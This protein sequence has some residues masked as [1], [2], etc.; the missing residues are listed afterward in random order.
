[1]QKN[2]LYTA[3]LSVFLSIAISSCDNLGGGSA[4]KFENQNLAGQS[5]GAQN[6]TTQS[7]NYT[8]NAMDLL[9][10]ATYPNGGVTRY[11][12]DGQGNEC[13]SRK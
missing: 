10:T 6:V 2:K 9:E 5:G 7:W 8:Y 13:W 11:D 4:S 3:L 1:M 12:Y